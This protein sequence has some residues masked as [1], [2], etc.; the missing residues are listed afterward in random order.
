FQPVPDLITHRRRDT[1]SAWLRYGLK[2]D[3][4]IDAVTENIVSFHDHIAQ[5]DA[6]TVKKGARCGHVTIAP[7][8]ALLEIHGAAQRLGDTMKSHEYP[9]AG[10]FDDT[11][12]TFCKRWVDQL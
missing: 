3:R 1:D 11:P 2:S 5:I 7:R 4:H 9:A 10:V 12:F 8:H 6:D